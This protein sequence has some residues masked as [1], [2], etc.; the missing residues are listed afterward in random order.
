M[1]EAC[2]YETERLL[3]TCVKMHMSMS[4]NM[5]SLVY[6]AFAATNSSAIP[7]HKINVPPMFSLSMIC[8]TANAAVIFNGIPELCP[9]PWPG[10]PSTMGLWYATPGYCEAF[11][12][13]STSLPR[14]MVGPSPLLHVAN[15]A[16]GIPE[17]PSTISKS[18]SFRIPV[19]YFDDSN[20]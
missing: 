13:Q 19:R 1:P 4:S 11:G 8:F 6:Q 5:P 12:M 20:S 15:Q 10:A 16:V 3:L 7:G 17:T 2:P 18:L 14:A 9:S